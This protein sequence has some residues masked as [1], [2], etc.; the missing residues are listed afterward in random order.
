MSSLGDELMRAWPYW[1]AA[2][3]AVAAA[4]EAA[5]WDWQLMTSWRYGG[6]ADFATVGEY[7]CPAA[8][9]REAGSAVPFESVVDLPLDENFGASRLQRLLMEAQSSA[10]PVLLRP[11]GAARSRQP[12]WEDVIEAV[13]G[14]AVTRDNFNVYEE[15]ASEQW[16]GLRRASAAEVRA[17]EQQLGSLQLAAFL[18]ANRAGKLNGMFVS[19]GIGEF[20]RGGS[21]EGP[22]RL[23]KEDLEEIGILRT[24]GH[25]P[26]NPADKQEYMQLYVQSADARGSAHVDDEEGATYFYLR[27]LEGRKRVRLWPVYDEKIL[28]AWMCELGADA[29]GKDP[30]L[31]YKMFRFDSHQWTPR[32]FQWGASA[33]GELDCASLRRS[34]HPCYVEF[35]MSSGDELFVPSGTPHQV[36]TLEPS[37]AMTANYRFSGG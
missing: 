32:G 13:A 25:Y 29:A 2:L 30:T 18:A 20:S 15:Q 10:R 17:Y 6:L 4:L 33:Q 14:V 31:A 9:W 28:D 22:A 5:R 21:G 35:I 12:G 8:S 11:Q 26:L 3:A 36:T 7:V 24:L 37:V 16:A 1:C 34:G 23:W 19:V 27:L